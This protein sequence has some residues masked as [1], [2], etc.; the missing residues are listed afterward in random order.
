[1]E[2][3]YDKDGPVIQYNKSLVNWGK[4]A[5]NPQMYTILSPITPAIVTQKSP[6]SRMANR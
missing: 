1:M 3:S 2:L 4:V 6:L 5:N